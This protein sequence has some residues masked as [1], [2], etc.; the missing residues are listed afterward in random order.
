MFLLFPALLF[1]QVS[2][3]AQKLYNEGEYSQ[4]KQLLER[5]LEE[6]PTDAY[7]NYLLG[8]TALYTGDTKTAEQSLA[9]A[10]KRNYH[11]AT[12]YLGRLYAMQYKFEAAEKEF[13]VY[14]RA[15]RRDKEALA[16]LEEE[17]EYAERVERLVS[18]TEDI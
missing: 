11:A 14:E 8:R 15:K 7:I 5:E 18:S 2:E 6:K 17:R 12:L 1:S 4:A 16:M 3:E 13:K 9:L 10:K